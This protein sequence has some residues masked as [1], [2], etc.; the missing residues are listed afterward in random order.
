MWAGSCS[1]LVLKIKKKCILQWII[2]QHI[3]EKKSSL[4]DTL[5]I[6]SRTPIQLTLSYTLEIFFLAEIMTVF[7][8]IY[9]RL[10]PQ[11]YSHPK[12]VFEVKYTERIFP[13]IVF[14]YR[15]VTSLAKKKKKKQHKKRRLKKVGIRTEKM[16][17]FTQT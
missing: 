1:F 13:Y 6:T 9:I 17:Q 7:Q 14:G 2:F 4:C 11:V 10:E 16:R 5:H 3:Q 15:S 8:I 12:Q